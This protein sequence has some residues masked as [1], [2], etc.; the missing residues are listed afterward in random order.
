MRL[1]ALAIISITVLE[2]AAL[3]EGINGTV[4]TMSV[5]V[6]AGLAGLATKRPKIFKEIY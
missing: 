3:R 6:V 4:F 1:I 2:L 5:G